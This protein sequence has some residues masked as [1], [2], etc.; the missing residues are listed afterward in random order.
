MTHGL[1]DTKIPAD[2]AGILFLADLAEPDTVGAA[3]LAIAEILFPAV[4]AGIPIPAD[5]AGILFPANLAEPDTVGVADVAV[6]GVAPLAVPDVFGGPEL[7]AM[8][9]ADELDTMNGIPIDYGGD[10]DDS[11]YKDPRNE[12]ETVYYSGGP[13]ACF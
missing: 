9:V 12:F 6:A 7:V 4:P 5:S 8:I 13:V 1:G 11:D 2:P 10:Y 3:D